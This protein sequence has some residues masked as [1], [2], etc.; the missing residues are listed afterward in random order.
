MKQKVLIITDRYWPVIGGTEYAAMETAAVLKECY[1]VAVLCCQVK[2]V[3]HARCES[4]EPFRDP[5]GI[6]VHPMSAPR[7]KKLFLFPLLLWYA[8]LVRR[9][10]S[11]P[12]FDFL[13]NFFSAA[14]S[15]CFQSH[16]AR[17]DVVHCFSISYSTMLAVPIAQSMGKKV[18]ISPF[19]HFGKWGDSPGF[20]QACKNADQL[21]SPT[22][23]MKE[24]LVARGIGSQKVCVLPP[25]MPP[26]CIHPQKPAALSDETA[27]VLFL[28][29][30]EPY[31]GFSQLAQVWQTLDTSLILVKAGGKHADRGEGIIDVGTVTTEEKQWLLNHCHCLCVPSLSESF[32]L[33]YLEAMRCGKPVVALDIPAVREIVS[34]GET[35]FL[36]PPGNP[37]ALRKALMRLISDRKK[38]TR[39]GHVAKGAYTRRYDC[40]NV[41]KKLSEL[42]AQLSST[43]HNMFED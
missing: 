11:K 19:I 36:V 26:V 24:A 25:L 32:G 23:S 12:A 15:T 29:R 14:Y 21:L 28:G 38:T 20:L 13:S 8:P 16:I 30:D 9:F 1:E 33:V 27:F 35:G 17:A 3:N 2:A 4:F 41:E 43:Q 37:E 40:E 22:S 6:V 10:F 18:I 39:M 5:N 31:K 34:H 42:Y 7:V